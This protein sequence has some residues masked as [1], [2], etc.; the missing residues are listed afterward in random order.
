M[1]EANISPR[2]HALAIRDRDTNVDRGQTVLPGGCPPTDQ[3]DGDKRKQHDVDHRGKD[4]EPGTETGTSQEI[5]RHE[6][7]EN[8]HPERELAHHDRRQNHARSLP[9]RSH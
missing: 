4:Q 9:Q 2:D 8:R 3:I 1:S 6:S 7:T 5:P